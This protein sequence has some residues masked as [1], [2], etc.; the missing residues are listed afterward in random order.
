MVLAYKDR[1]A[2]RDRKVYKENP[3]R[4][5]LAYKDRKALRDSLDVRDRLGWI[6]HL[7]L[8]I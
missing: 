3:E 2:L 1:K 6:R 4:M 5:V 7:N 8:N